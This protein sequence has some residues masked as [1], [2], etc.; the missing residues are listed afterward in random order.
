[1]KRAN[2]FLW[3][4]SLPVLGASLVSALILS[5]PV[6]ASQREPDGR[7]G[8]IQSKLEVERG[9][10]RTKL[11]VGDEVKPK[12]FLRTGGMARVGFRDG[13]IINMGKKTR[14]RIVEHNAET[15]QTIL[16]VERG[17]VR[18]E[19]HNLPAGG[20]IEVRTPAATFQFGD[21]HIFLKVSG[22]STEIA[23]FAGDIQASNA[24]HITQ[25]NAGRKLELHSSGKP[26][27]DKPFYQWYRDLVFVYTT[28][29]P[30]KVK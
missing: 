6:A 8:A 9:G 2:N 4:V 24:G 20:K 28:V 19:R 25:V 7:V 3:K 29:P 21:G 1:M 27:D 11:Q 10:A 5:A 30:M 17:M 23:V 16:E 26:K 22:G 14:V 18:I 12:D 15:G 13:L